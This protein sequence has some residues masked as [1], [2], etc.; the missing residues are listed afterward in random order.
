MP[1]VSS[2]HC[3][4]SSPKHIVNVECSGPVLRLT[5]EDAPQGLSAAAARKPII[6]A[7]DAADTANVSSRLRV[8]ES[9]PPSSPPAVRHSLTLSPPKFLAAEIQP[10]ASTPPRDISPVQVI[11]YYLPFGHDP[12][13]YATPVGTPLRLASPFAEAGLPDTPR[14]DFS[15]LDPLDP[16]DSP[17]PRGPFDSPNLLH[18]LNPPDA[19]S[20]LDSPSC[21]ALEVPSPPRADGSPPPPRLV[22]GVEDLP[23]SASELLAESSNIWFWRIIMLL[24]SWVQLHYHLPHRGVT[25]MLQVMRL[26]LLAL[27]VIAPDDRTPTALRTAFARLALQDNFV[28][29]A[30]CPQCARRF[31]TEKCVAIV[32]CNKCKIPLCI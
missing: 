2:C 13:D 19:P 25:L 12:S 5:V 24:G 7:A 22:Q 20:P 14:S 26:V 30:M 1:A 4:A 8:P 23:T 3:C 17:N 10:A 29:R 31:P 21:Q 28:V 9:S 27:G 16:L 6:P 11:D 15:P 18:P 32:T